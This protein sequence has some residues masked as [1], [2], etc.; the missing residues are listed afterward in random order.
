MVAALL[1]ACLLLLAAEICTPSFGILAVAG[2]ACWV[3][4]VWV[5]YDYNASFGV[6]MAVVSCFA[7]LAY[8]V[9][10]VRYLP[11]TP[12]GKLLQLRTRRAPP[13]EGTPEAVQEENL[14]GREGLAETVLR[15]SGAIRIEGKRVIARAETGFIDAGR[16]VKVIA[17][18]GMNVVVSEV[19]DA[20]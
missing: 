17:S 1:V 12:L 13:G 10:A 19:T 16:K 11:K 4:A 7:I 20:S 9:L 18:D 3:G 14:V 15:P 6:I 8:L 5:C 2:V